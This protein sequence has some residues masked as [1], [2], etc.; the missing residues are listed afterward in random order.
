M[1]SP[2]RLTKFSYYLD[3]AIYPAL[4]VALVFLKF[5]VSGLSLAWFRW[6]VVGFIA[7]TL[8]EYWLHRIVF[9]GIPPAIANMHIQH[10]SRPTEFIGVPVWYSLAFFLLFSLPVLGLLGWETGSGTIVGLLMGYILY[11]GIHDAAH[12]RSSFLR[13]WFSR[14]RVNHLRHHYQNA[15]AGFGVTTDVWDRLFGTKS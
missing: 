12:H 9:H 10:H 6:W 2:W 11:I 5:K 3:F 15:H 13:P 7:W 1:M 4:I 14:F 8:I